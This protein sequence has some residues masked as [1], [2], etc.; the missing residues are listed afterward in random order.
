MS[1]T[2]RVYQSNNNFFFYSLHEEV[3]ENLRKEGGRE[4][5]PDCIVI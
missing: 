1:K 5:H 2:T 4:K 3:D